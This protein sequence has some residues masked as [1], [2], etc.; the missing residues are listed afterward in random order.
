MFS[1][2]E[3][4]A[5]EA[6]EITLS[7]IS[8]ILIVFLIITFALNPRKQQFPASAQLWICV[9]CTIGTLGVDMT[10]LVGGNQN[11]QCTWDTVPV[12]Q[13]M[14]VAGDNGG[15]GVVC[16][17][18]AIFIFYGILAASCWCLVMS[19]VVFHMLFLQ[20]FSRTVLKWLHIAAHIFCWG[21]PALMIIIVLAAQQMSSSMPVGFTCFVNVPWDLGVFFVPVLLSLVLGTLFITLSLIKVA[22]MRKIVKQSKITKEQMFRILSV[23]LVF[24]GSLLYAIIYRFYIQATMNSVQDA[25]NEQVKCS[26]TTGTDCPLSQKF[27]TGAWILEA[28]VLG[29]GGIIVFVFLGLS[30][31]TLLFWQTIIKEKDLSLALKKISG[32]LEDSP[33]G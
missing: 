25:V 20:I 27:N 18:Q 7:I 5:A 30:R 2:S 3:W 8:T 9:S 17:F 16:I 32:K 11:M 1:E 19:Y 15:Q 6:I 23:I 26:A 28:F 21:Y 29:S 31:D 14:S 24:W 4:H 10:V 33:S 12:A 22:W 13:T